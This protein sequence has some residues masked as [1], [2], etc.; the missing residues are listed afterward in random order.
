[1]DN[2]YPEYRVYTSRSQFRGT[3]VFEF[4]PGEFGERIT[5]YNEA[6]V[7]VREEGFVPFQRM[8]LTAAP[9]FEWYGETRLNLQQAKHWLKLLDR[10]AN[11]ITAAGSADN[12]LAVDDRIRVTPE[13]FT[14]RK[15][16]LT[17]T[18]LQLS[19][20]V[21]RAVR[22]QCSLWVLGL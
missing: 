15:A 14:I 17:R 7:Y 2:S 12:L 3:D 19:G 13:N 8:L 1:M 10:A 6:S 5:W 11:A 21:E 18:V 22:W 20:V 9:R 4:Y 16:Q